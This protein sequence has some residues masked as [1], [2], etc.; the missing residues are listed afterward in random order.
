MNRGVQIG[1]QKVFV[2]A[3]QNPE[4]TEYKVIWRD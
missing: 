3:S 4:S 1:F 2:Q